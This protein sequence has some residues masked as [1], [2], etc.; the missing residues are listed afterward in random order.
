MTSIYGTLHR[1]SLFLPISMLDYA[2]I[3]SSLLECMAQ[4][5]REPFD[6]R[7]VAGC[8]QRG[9]HQCHRVCHH[10]HLLDTFG[11]LWPT[12]MQ[13]LDREAG[14]ALCVH[15]IFLTASLMVFV[16]QKTAG[17]ASDHIRIDKVLS[18]TRS[19]EG[20][21]LVIAVI[22][23]WCIRL[24]VI[25]NPGKNRSSQRTTVSRLLA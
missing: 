8:D 5:G 14:P 4:V 22:I 17:V 9:C 12:S 21:S 24:A 7:T 25:R 11:I 6:E 10:C 13:L 16:P 20:R 1:I 2:R 3:E 23:V 15:S 18:T 19:I